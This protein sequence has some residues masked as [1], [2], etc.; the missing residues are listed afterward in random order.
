[1]QIGKTLALNDR[2]LG[3]VAKYVTYVVSPVAVPAALVEIPT[4]YLNAQYGNFYTFD[5][6]SDILSQVAVPNACTTGAALKYMPPSGYGGVII[7]EA[8]AQYAMGVY[9]VA[10]SQGGS[11]GTPFGLWDFRTCGGT[12]KWNAV[13]QG[14][15]NAGS[16]TYTTYVMTGSVAQVANLMH[17]LYSL[18]LDRVI[19]AR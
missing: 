8:T 9:G 13:Y 7:S 6:Q 19:A 11:I 4:A 14:P 10:K 2:G 3:P 5:A 15:I 16:N 1:M 12:T 18:S 17:I